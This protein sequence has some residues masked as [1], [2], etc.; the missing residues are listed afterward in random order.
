M[1]LAVGLMEFPTADTTGYW[2]WAD[3]RER[4]C[5]RLTPLSCDLI[6]EQH[7]HSGRACGRHPSVHVRRA[8]GLAGDVRSDAS[9][10]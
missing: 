2:R 3:L 9:K 5:G 6:P 4:T 1:S 8:P 10:R 7:D